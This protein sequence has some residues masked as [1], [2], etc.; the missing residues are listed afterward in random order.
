M[1]PFLEEHLTY[2]PLFY[3]HSKTKPGFQPKA[4]CGPGELVPAQKFKKKKKN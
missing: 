2:L 4:L 1:L 3:V